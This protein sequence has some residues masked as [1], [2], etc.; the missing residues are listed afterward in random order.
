MKKVKLIS[1]GLIL[2]LLFSVFPAQGLTAATRTEQTQAAESAL[3][4]ETGEAAEE[5]VQ[6]ETLEIHTAEDFMDFTEHCYIDGW[7]RNREVLLKEDINLSEVDFQMIPVFAGTFDGGGHTIS[8]FN[9]DSDGYM[10]GLFRYIEETGVVRNLKLLGT[11]SGTE[12]EECIGGICGVNYG[13]IRNCSF[14]GVV[15][16][17]YKVGGIAGIN[18][19]TG[20]I[21]NCSV[22]GRIT[23]YYMTG[24]IVGANYG[25]VTSCKNYSK[26]NNDSD[27]VEE[28]DEIGIGIFFSINVSDSDTDLYSGV[29]T[30]GISGYSNGVI[31]RCVN[32]GGIGYEH[33]GYNIGGIAG[34][35]AG[36]LSLCTNNGKVYGRKDV[37]GI[38]GQM[39]PYIEVDEAESLRNAINKLHDL[40]NKTLDDIHAEK[41]AV[42]ADFDSLTAYGDGALNSGNAMVEQM[43][44]FV[45]SNMEQVRIFNERMEY[46][47]D[48]LPGI[49]D[50][51]SAAQDAFGH[52]S[53]AVKNFIGDVSGNNA[54]SEN[55]LVTVTSELQGTLDNVDRT[56]I[57]IREIAEDWDGSVQ[58]WSN[59][60]DGQQDALVQEIV[61]LT[62][63]LDNMSSANSY[64]LIELER[65]LPELPSDADE[66]LKEAATYLQSMSDSL[67]NASNGA[68]DVVNYINAQPDLQFTTLG[69]EFRTNRT[70]LHI[71]LV[72]ISDSLKRLGDNASVY[73]DAV[74]ADLKA[75]NNQLN[76]VFNLLAD[77]MSDYGNLSVEELYEEVPDDEIDSITTGR[78]DSCTNTGIVKGDINIGGIAG[79]MSIDEE[80]PEDSAAGSVKYEIGR[81]FITKCIITNCVN[82][83]YV[84]A[85]KDGAGG[86]VGYM[87]H[88]IVTDSESYG[89]IESIEGGYVGGIC[90][91]SLTII[92]RCYAL[93]SVSGGRNVGGIAGYADTLKD[94]YVIVDVDATGG[95]KGAIA[96]QI[97]SYDNMRDSEEEEAKVCRNYYV[98]DDV[99]GIDNISFVGIAEP[100]VYEELLTIE[101][102][103]T[104]FRH[105]KV[106]Y[107][108]EDAFLGSEE[109]AYGESL[110]NLQYP[111]IPDRE[112]CYGVWPDYSGEV[113][114]GY[115]V[116]EGEYRD[117]VIVVAS[118]EKYAADADGEYGR[119]LALVE[120]IFTEETTLNVRMGDMDPPGEVSGRDY[121][122]YH[123]FL[124]NGSVNAEDIFAVRILNPYKDAEVWGYDNGVWTK[125]ENKERGRY[126]QVDMAGE[127][128][129]FCVVKKGIINPLIIIIA[130]AAAAAVFILFLLQKRWKIY[131]N[132]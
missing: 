30:G 42:K 67:K 15:S 102:L 66:N 78:T 86:I 83:G 80:D 109:V 27:W 122:V 60:S 97:A 3:D 96:G 103:P 35:Q 123:L 37:G 116:V 112:G 33:T 120:Q 110:A 117:N 18:E 65:A 95:N 48:S 43:T 121:V 64:A 55:R 41:N 57:A 131:K 10:T 1:L 28:D 70:N 106:I 40:I 34:R 49:L 38:V 72:G 128:A 108:I 92:R 63:H 91:E 127:E 47:M 75:V 13:T 22:R 74:N 32:H 29:D 114:K 51:V 21:S 132:K 4:A 126:L 124:E 69:S 39:E 6:I 129:F 17:R 77:H 111:Q 59:L 118:D 8:G 89:E 76:I 61:N 31:S 130:T 125:L 85:K 113:M 44:D 7:S 87:V 58:E 20:T 107:R 5:N 25:V 81:H 98:G 99:H 93:C 79:S 16:G 84:T 9:S 11:A 105:L 23:G 73:S 50:D 46:V 90:G 119:P 2:P 14:Q 82:E 54:G 45:D 88:G 53:D 52:F 19:S 56:K 100:I 104:T 26:I 12:E 24:G 94:C 68:R 115:L 101:K 62:G 71:Q 36:V